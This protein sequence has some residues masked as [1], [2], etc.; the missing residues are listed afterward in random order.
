LRAILAVLHQLVN[1]ALE[2]ELR[3]ILAE[4]PR[5]DERQDAVSDRISRM[6]GGIKVTFGQRISES[7]LREAARKA[8]NRVAQN[9]RKQLDRQ[10]KIA[11]GI[12]PFLVDI[13]M[14]EHIDLFVKENVS[15]ITSVAEKSFS[16]IEQIVT[17]GARSGTGA[18]G[19][20]KLIQKRFEVAESRA[21]LIA[22]DQTAKLFGEI[23]ELRQREL[24]VD[25]Y[26]WRTSQ[27]ERVRARHEFLDG[28]PQKWSKPP[29]VDV[30]SG[31]R[32][33]PGF[34]YQCRCVAEPILPE[35]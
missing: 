31:R 5:R 19:I 24:G 21:N 23:N 29:I 1:A 34:D 27:D 12:D 35:D 18:E 6:I 4:A 7:R 9:Q 25:G 11:T 3:A 33:H 17:R 30:K 15:L 20:S 10:V 22:R 28:K 26:T 14:P 32:A 16:E 8:G 2:R 13:H